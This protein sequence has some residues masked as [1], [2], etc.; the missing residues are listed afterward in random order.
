MI[1]FKDI[2]SE[3]NDNQK[4]TVY[5]GTSLYNWQEIQKSGFFTAPLYVTTRYESSEEFAVYIDGEQ[6]FQKAQDEL[7][8]SHYNGDWQK[9]VIERRPDH[10]KGRLQLAYEFYKDSTP[11]ILELLVDLSDFERLE[12]IETDDGAYTDNILSSDAVVDV[13]EL[14]WHELLSD[15]G[16]NP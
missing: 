12:N 14:S 2:L 10:P 4:T 1:K 3:A 8:K 15:W 6:A 13:H 5:H 16:L 11:V 7:V 9:F